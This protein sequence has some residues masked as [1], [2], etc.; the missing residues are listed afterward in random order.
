MEYCSLNKKECVEWSTTHWKPLLNYVH[1]ISLLTN[2]WLVFMFLEDKDATL[3]L[4]SLWTIHKKSLVLS[5]W[6]TSFDPLHERVVKHHLWVLLPALPFPLWNIDVFIGLTNT[7]GR[8]V[9]VEKDFHLIF[10]KHMAWV[11]VELDISSGLL[12]EINIVC[13]DK[14]ICQ[15]LD[16]LNVPFRCNFCHE[17]SHLRSTFTSLLHSLSRPNGFSKGEY[18]IFYFFA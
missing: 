1:T 10:D 9:V 17:T 14:V 4:N 3:I 11:L 6:H 8:F 5:K 2:H 16:Y 7:L 18:S 13:N 12:L 15:R